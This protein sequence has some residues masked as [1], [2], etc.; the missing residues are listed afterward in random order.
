M[1]HYPKFLVK[2]EDEFDSFNYPQIGHD[3]DQINELSVNVPQLL[4]AEILISFTKNHSLKNEWIS[5]NPKFAR[6]VTNG[7]LPIGNI[8]S[9]FE[10]SSKNSY[11]QN[12][13]EQYLHQSINYMTT[14]HQLPEDD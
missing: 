10:G 3:L 2:A 5:A 1:R 4:K 7:E 13:F 14:S 11:F 9:L 12:Q 8:A 6:L